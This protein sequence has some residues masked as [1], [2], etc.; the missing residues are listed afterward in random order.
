MDALGREAFS[1]AYRFLKQFEEVKIINLEMNE[2]MIQ[3]Y[4]SHHVIIIM[5]LFIY[6]F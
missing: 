1:E 4:D 2:F 3:W 6:L 5:W